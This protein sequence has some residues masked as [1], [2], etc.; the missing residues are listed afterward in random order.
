[1]TDL[2]AFAGPLWPYL[3]VVL[4]G[5]LPTEIWRV[6]GG[7][8][9]GV[10]EQQGLNSVGLAVFINEVQELHLFRVVEL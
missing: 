10:G 9:D 6:L 3:V 1:M 7:Y 8:G 5:F 2:A 4:V